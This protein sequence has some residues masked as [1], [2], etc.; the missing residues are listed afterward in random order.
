MEIYVTQ[1]PV[2]GSGMLLSTRYPR[3][4]SFTV[5][6]IFQW[7][8]DKNAQLWRAESIAE[9]Q[10][11]GGEAYH[12]DGRW[13]TIKIADPG[14]PR[15]GKPESLEWLGIKIQH[16]RWYSMHYTVTPKRWPNSSFARHFSSNAPL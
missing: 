1:V 15:G 5:K 14:D 13:L 7:F 4:T 16:A 12:F 8:A 9:L 11:A 2:K 10:R 6:R 3:G